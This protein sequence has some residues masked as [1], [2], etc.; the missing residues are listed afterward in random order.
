MRLRAGQDAPDFRTKDIFDR[1]IILND[2]KG[3]KVMLSFYRF[4]ACPFCNLRVNKLMNL[5]KRYESQGLKMLSFWQ[6]PKE[7]VHEHAKRRNPPFPMISDP[8]K[9]IYSLYR[10]ENDWKGPIK[11][12]LEPSLSIDAMKEGINV[13]R[14]DGE[15]DLIPADFLINPDL[16]IH[17][18]FYGKHIGDH[19]PFELI[20]A[21]ISKNE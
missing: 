13:K 7:S 4:S 14:V 10:I 11:V 18:A 12:L 19:I 6:S 8:M 9:E 3:S 15:M 1:E 20:E 16:S 2:Y 5:T 17:T 21:F